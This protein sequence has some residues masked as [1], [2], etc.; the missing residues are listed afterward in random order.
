MLSGLNRRK[1]I[2]DTVV[3]L[4]THYT[5]NKLQIIEGMVF[6][7]LDVSVWL[8]NNQNQTEFRLSTRPYLKSLAFE[9]QSLDN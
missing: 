6:K 9:N 3:L 4:A 8:L 2:A 7:I 1:L 5:L